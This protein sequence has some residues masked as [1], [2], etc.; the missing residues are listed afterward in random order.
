M[1]GLHTAPTG[2]DEAAEAVSPFRRVLRGAVLA[3]LG[4]AAGFAIL[5]LAIAALGSGGP[6][7]PPPP[8][9]GARYEEALAVLARLQDKVSRTDPVSEALISEVNAAGARWN[10]VWLARNPSQ[11]GSPFDRL[12]ASLVVRR[13]DGITRAF[14]ALE[15]EV[16]VELRARRYGEALAALARF[17]PEPSLEDPVRELV[18]RVHRAVE[19]DFAA[20]QGHGEALVQA[21]RYAEASRWF[22]QHAP[23]FR[24]TEQYRRLADR[25]ESLGELAKAEEA[26]AARE[27]EEERARAEE[28]LRRLAASKAPPPARDGPREPATALSPFLAKL[29]E[30]INAGHLASKTYA[31]T[32]AISGSPIAAAPGGITLGAHRVSWDGIAPAAL[33][34]MAS[35]AFQGED[36]LLAADHAAAARLGIEVD[37]LLWQ[38]LGGGDRKERQAKVDATLARFRGLA[39]VPEGGFTYDPA[40]GWEDRTQ[41]ANRTAVDEAARHLKAML[42]APDPKKREDAFE[43]LR[44]TYLQSGLA[45]EPRE[46]IRADAVAGFR[47]LKRRKIEDIGKKAKAASALGPLR[48]LKQ[49]LNQRREEALKV[50]YNPK[51]YLPEDDPRWAPGNDAVTGQKL[52]DELVGKVREIWDQPGQAVF[53][54]SRAVERDLEEIKAVN[55]RYLAAFGEEADPE[56]ELA[57]LEEIRNNLNQ[58]L[59]VRSYCLKGSDRQDWEWN[60]RVD[61][62]NE[63]LK[64][65][66]VTR[67]EIEHAKVVNDYREMMGRRRCFLDARLCRA[68][69]KHSAVCDRAGKIWHVGSDGDPQSRARAEGFSGPVAENVAMGYSSP[70]EIWTRGWY[71][72]SDHHRNGLND[73]WNC[74]GYG[75]SGSVGTENFSSIGPPKGF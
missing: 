64:G 49:L 69:K 31:V 57:S 61:K 9:P 18:A 12:S 45:D 39:A 56:E 50:I 75:Y 3:G 32:P 26:R 67:E 20:I 71:R 68:T 2:P 48:A 5:V 41:R 11:R 58:A 1:A 6:A 46:R 24:G 13:A 25:P 43:K 28:H 30:A 54:Q 62:Y 55:E 16:D 52:V 73:S 33:M 70:G 53:E 47:E 15:A 37:R 29:A 65:A 42:A 66:G 27:R 7:T 51:I 14:A 40:V 60:R 74:L 59:S 38:Y 4:L 63:G 72:A 10:P 19:A 44:R 21:R 22:A 8:D 34:A 23:R 17:K 36:L 35:D